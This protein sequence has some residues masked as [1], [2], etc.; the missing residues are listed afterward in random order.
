[1]NTDPIR[2]SEP[3][4][5]LQ[6]GRVGPG[7]IAYRIAVL[8]L[9]VG[10]VWLLSRTTQMVQMGAVKPAWS[11]A[12]TTWRLEYDWE[13]DGKKERKSGVI[14]FRADGAVAERGSGQGT[15]EVMSSD[16]ILLNPKGL[17]SWSV[18]QKSIEAERLV[19]ALA[20]DNLVLQ[21]RSNPLSR[22]VL[23]RVHRS[24]EQHETI[25]REIQRLNLELAAQGRALRSELETIRREV[26]L[27]REMEK[28]R[29]E[30]GKK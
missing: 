5:T 29:I 8:L 18:S 15:F 14:E 10:C 9:L 3:E 25:I 27:F 6:T 4:P 26:Q 23:Q 11:L 22:V 24:D 1:M 30:D 17:F 7:M 20:G 13:V 16:E 21:R 28:K 19:V 12:G 2:Q